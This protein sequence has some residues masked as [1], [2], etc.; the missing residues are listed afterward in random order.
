M[1]STNTN[2]TGTHEIETELASRWIRLVG[3]IIDGLIS[4]AIIIPIMF[5]TGVLQ[6][7]YN[8]EQSLTFGVH[9]LLL[10]M[11][12][13]VFLILN[14]YLLFNRGQTIGKLVV[15]TR[16]VD[17]NGNIPNFGKLLILRYFTLGLATQIPFIGSFVGLVDAIFIFGKERRC[18]HDYMAGT[19]VVNVKQ[20]S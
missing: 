12:W 9:V 7:L 10:V 3:A 17:L 6:Q 4:M 11:G 1:D 5:F 14:G 15:K 16:I 18:L 2:E 13:G 19:R 8:T 20:S